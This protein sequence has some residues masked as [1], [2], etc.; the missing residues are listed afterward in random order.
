MVDL[1]IRSAPCNK[2]LT[3]SSVGETGSVPGYSL[4]KSRRTN[5]RVAGM[6]QT[7]VLFSLLRNTDAM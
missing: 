3:S 1:G 5:K 6:E 2:I 4:Y 7:T